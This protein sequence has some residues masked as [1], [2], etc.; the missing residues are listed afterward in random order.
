[1]SDEWD[2][3][4]WKIERPTPNPERD[5]KLKTTLLVILG[6]GALLGVYI[7]GLSGSREVAAPIIPELTPVPTSA[8]TPTPGP[9]AAPEPVPRDP[10]AVELMLGPGEV[11]GELELGDGER[12]VIFCRGSQADNRVLPVLAML[13]VVATPAGGPQLLA[14][15]RLA[16]PD[17]VFT[18]CE[19]CAPERV[20]LDG[21]DVLFGSCAIRGLAHHTTAYTIAPPRQGAASPLALHLS[22]GLTTL[23]AVEDRLVLDKFNPD[24]S[25][26]FQR[27]DG[28]FL[29]DDLE[30]LDWSCD[31]GAT[32]Q[33]A[34]LAVL[35]NRGLTQLSLETR[36]SEI[37][38]VGV[39][40]QLVMASTF[41]QCA[42]LFDASFRLAAEPAVVPSATAHDAEP[43]QPI[44]DLLG[45]EPPAGFTDWNY[46]CQV[47]R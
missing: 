23:A 44:A 9:T 46:A 14:Y 40:G 39:H 21:D 17:L 15:E 4:E 20:E 38:E 25:I 33:L 45:I 19:A 22:C 34:G 2:S 3:I 5:T 37:G 36:E 30:L 41:E 28:T 35:Q 7:L 8:P 6:F 29:A 32:A 26:S 42:S 18:T 12:A 10:D 43:V 1:M 16:T 13:H 47:D 27:R 31:L 11:L 24:T